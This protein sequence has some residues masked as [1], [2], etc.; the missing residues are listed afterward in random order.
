MVGV[1]RM[2]LLLGFN[3]AAALTLRKPAPLRDRYQSAL[4]FN[5]AAALT[6]RKLPTMATYGGS[7]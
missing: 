2:V 4:R 6:L 1:V 3:G 5:G 7:T